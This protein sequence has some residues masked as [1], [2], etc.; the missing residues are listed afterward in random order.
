M[1]NEQ[2]SISALLNNIKD[3]MKLI[4][5]PYKVLILDD[6]STDQSVNI[7]KKHKMPIKIV[8]HK[9]NKGLGQTINDLLIESAKITKDNDVIVTMDADNTHNPML[10]KEMLDVIKEND[11]VIASRY[12]KGGKELGLKTYRKFLSR[13]ISIIL[14]FFINIKNVKDY[15][16]GYRMYRASLLKKT[17]NKFPKIV[18]STGFPGMAE[19]LF[20]LKKN[21]VKAA[22]VPLILRYDLKKGKSKMNIKKTIFEYFKMISKNIH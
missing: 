10:I 3:S 6:G 22:E 15:T 12:E 19:I 20:K 18:D 7:V 8:H 1:Y 2:E 14:N 21:H 11:L 16:C 9:K 5:Q 4:N 17:I 13:I